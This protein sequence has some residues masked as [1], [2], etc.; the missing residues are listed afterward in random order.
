M[1]HTRELLRREL[2]NVSMPGGGGCESSRLD[3][4]PLPSPFS[5]FP[6]RPGNLDLF[7]AILHPPVPE[8]NFVI[9]LTQ[10]DE[11]LSEFPVLK[12]NF[13]PSRIFWTYVFFAHRKSLNCM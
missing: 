5:V 7:G 10:F 1:P 6:F 8:K 9:L 12:R 2:E 11:K 3:A 13:I 4:C